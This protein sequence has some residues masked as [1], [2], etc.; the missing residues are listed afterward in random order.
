VV[1]RIQH[2]EGEVLRTAPGHPATLDDP[3]SY[4]IRVTGGRVALTGSDLGGILNSVVFGYAGAPLR[5]LAVRTDGN[6]IVQTGVMHKGVDFRFRLRGTLSLMPDGRVRIHP[7]EVR[8]LGLNG[9]K[10][11]HLFGLHLDNLLDLSKARGATV[12]GDDLFLDPISI[13]PPPAID[14][15]L[16]TIA[17]DGP[18]I[19]EDFVRLPDDSVFGG[20]VRADTAFHNFVYFRGGELQFGKLLMSNTDLRIVDADPR[21][22]FDLNLPHYTK[23]LVAGTSHTLGNQGLLVYMPD[24][25]R[26]GVAPAGGPTASD[27]KSR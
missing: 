15:R 14:G 4:R 13:L 21:T 9:E 23:Q 16:A 24:F 20:F 2:L 27:R 25:S 6:E 7:S 19:A 18:R 10:V 5:N 22:P 12:K 17:V 1:V 26:L 8:V 3:K 11:L